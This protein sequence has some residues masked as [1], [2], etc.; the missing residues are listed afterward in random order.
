MPENYISACLVK[1]S[2]TRTKKKKKS[3]K[4]LEGKKNTFRE[5]TVFSR[6]TIDKDI[7]EHFDSWF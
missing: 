1:Y 2:N 6:I 5:R 3:L 7:I 4:N